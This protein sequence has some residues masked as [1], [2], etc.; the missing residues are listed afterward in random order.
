MSYISESVEQFVNSSMR[1]L[2]GKPSLART[3]HIARFLGEVLWKN[4]VGIYQLA[5]IERMLVDRVE[6]LIPEVPAWRFCRF[7]HVLTK[8]YDTGGHTRLVE[9]LVTSEALSDSKVFVTTATN[10]AAY[11]R[12]KKAS[13][14]CTL[15]PHE[16]KAEVRIAS[17]V[18]AFSQCE[19]LV[20]YIHPY[21]IESVIAAGIAK[22]R[23][24]VCVLLF[25][26]ADH[27]FSWG[28]GLAD[29]VLEISH[30]GWALR[31]K[32]QS[33]DRSV[34]VGIPLPLQSNVEPRFDQPSKYRGMV[35]AA[36]TAYK[37]RPAMGLS[38]PKF[39]ELL[40]RRVDQSV[41]VVG[42]NRWLDW[43]WWRVICVLKGR[44][45][46]RSRLEYEKYIA[47]VSESAAF[48]DSF[49]LAGG[50][51]FAEVIA[52]GIPGFGVLTGSHGYSPA[53]LVKSDSVEA[54]IEEMHH[55]L[56]SGTRIGIDDSELL[57]RLR[58][59]HDVEKV[60]FRVA[61]AVSED[62]IG[63]APPWP[64]TVDVDIGFFERIWAERDMP[65]MP[66]H[67]LPPLSLVIPFIR[68]KRNS[69]LPNK[70][71]SHHSRKNQ[72]YEE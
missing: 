9:R 69:T 19:I 10:P 68:L 18:E 52:R 8:A 6:L 40:C 64:C 34:F 22:R 67:V 56:E 23:S 61:N 27:V 43:W 13:H 48:V 33:E 25:N 70:N 47:L 38:F 72:R 57:T 15:L 12:L 36:G 60:A 5:E 16:K 2:A 31:G 28:Y 26:H 55:F 51:A 29:R 42:P 20:L 65:V 37:F 21:D 71:F 32:R 30:Y 24:G 62:G 7:G 49:P 17:L 58:E 3:L 44:L 59:V 46:I 39:L 35:M 45:T 41:A 1:S 53:D 50:T 54:L 14:G 11:E 66:V 4:S 63:A